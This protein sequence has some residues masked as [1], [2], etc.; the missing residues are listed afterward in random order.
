MTP[1]LKRVILFSMFGRK[2][3]I[4]PVRIKVSMERQAWNLKDQLLEAIRLKG[5][6]VNCHAH[7]DKAFY[8]TKEGLAKSMVEMEQKWLMSDEIKKNS[9]QAT[10][11]ERIRT[12][13]DLLIAQ[14]CK[15]TCSFIDAYAAVGHKAIDAANKVKEEYKDKITLLTITQPLGGLVDV[16][17]RKLY[18][19]ITAKADIAGGLPSKDRPNDRQNLDNLFAIAKNLNKKLHVHI[20]QENNPN[21]H[22]TEMLIEYTKKYGYQ[23]KVTAIHAI[24]VSAQP[25]A[26]RERIYKEM[27]EVGMSVVV[28]PSA[29]LGMRQLDQFNSP[30]H[31]SMANIPEMLATGVTVGL[32]VDNVYDFYQPFVDADMYTELRMLMEACRFYKFNELVEIATTNGRKILE[33]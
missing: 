30:V 7:F 26:D 8:I 21:E 33:N 11:E 31:N 18:E 13:V 22:D 3:P 1:V 4:C 24:S 20:D 12:A 15:T 5:G 29:A 32:G 25:K 23:G 28:C 10:I 27:S 6:W 19:E 2:R 17:A 9:S 16:E 14:N